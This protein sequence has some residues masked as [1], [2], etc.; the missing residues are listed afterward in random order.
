MFTVDQVIRDNYPALEQ[1]PWLAKPLKGVLRRLLHERDINDFAEKYPH[2]NGLDFVE[3]VLDYFCFSYSISDRDKARIPATGRV[4]IIA[5]HP[6]GSL[7]GL[8]L[9]KLVAEIR[10]DVKAVVN[11]LLMNVKPLTPM[12]LPVNNMTGNTAKECL[13]NIESH[14]QT[15][16]ALIIFPAGEVSRLHPTGVKDSRWRSGFLKMATQTQAPI[17]PMFVSGRNSALF[18]SASMIYKPLS[19]V[20]LVKEMFRQRDKSL[21]V[22]VGEPI[23]YESYSSLNMPNRERVKLFKRHLYRIAKGRKGLFKTFSAIAHP[24]SRA[25]LKHAIEQC[26]RLGETADGKQIYLYRFTESSPIMREIGRLR[27]VSF[28]AVGEGTGERRDM[29]SY[30]AHYLHLVLWDREDLEIVGAYRLADTQRVIDEKGLKG[31]YTSSLFD[32]DK[33]M[34]K[35]LPQGVELGR[36]FVQPR[37]WGKRSLDYLWYGI[38]AFLVKYPG[39]RYLFGPVSI[40]NSFPKPARDLLVFF[41]KLYFSSKEPIAHSRQPYG[42]ADDTLQT[43]KATFSG[44]DYKED[45]TQLKHLLANMGVSVPTLYKQ[46]TEVAEQDGVQF[47]DFGIDP[48]FADCVDGLVLV[49]IAKLKAK[50]RARYMGAADVSK[51]S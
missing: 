38:G 2:L 24:E 40:S 11:E 9:L 47:L 10:S 14:L 12:L 6:I 23:P 4:V 20:L 42:I 7:D 37:Y 50:K 21:T 15:D 44:A 1:K 18:Y 33:Q 28:R 35:Y 29:D 43:L 19:T 8:A 13:K 48:D 30:D 39:Y 17:V 51:A 5:N 32:F 34:D 31:L 22:K 26:E 36:S 45:F 46:Y 16:G 25:E 27:E 41:Y 49:D 3:K